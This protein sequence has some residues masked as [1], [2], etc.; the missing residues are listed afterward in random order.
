MTDE[1]GQARVHGQEAGEGVW[2]WLLRPVDMAS[3]AAF[4]I[5][6]GLMLCG[7]T[8]RF[9]ASGWLEPFFGEPTFFFKYWGFSWVRPLPLWGM[10]LL[11]G[12]L[13]VLAL[14]VALGFLYRLSMA[15]FT[16]GFA[17]AQLIDVTNYLNHYY[18]VVL[19]GGLMVLLPLHR[20]W[21]VDAWLRPRLRSTTAPAWVL[22]LLRLQVGLVYFHAGL[23]KF[24]SDWLL[25]AQPLNIWMSARTDTL[26]I[27][28]LLELPWVAYAMSWA[29]FLF[30]T[31]IVGF[32]LARRT[33]PFAYAVVLAFHFLTG[34]FFNIGLF[35]VIMVTSALVF[36]PPEWPRHLLR[37][38]LPVLPPAPVRPALSW[39]GKAGF[40]LLGA[41]C[42]FQAV[43][44]LRHFLYPGSVLWN[45][46]GMRWSW[47]VMLREKS[48]S[49]TYHVRSKATGREWQVTPSRYLTWRQAQEM[50]GQ[51]DLILQ[52]AHHVAREFE[53]QG[54]GP[55]EVRAEAWVSLNGR[56]PALLID[57]TVDLTQVEDGLL[58]AQWI[59]PEPA[60]PPPLLRAPRPRVA[61]HQP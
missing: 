51:P 31:T 57:R 38:P 18:L 36:F 44:P 14:C 10:Y 22:Y 39:A 42:L 43:F 34:T 35:P 8:L 16:L 53:Q 26:L 1:G 45:E 60:E 46:E 58:P 41:F 52:L 59:L 49:I 48:G 23:A 30:D 17:W 27:G 20:T 3:L 15:L 6:F 56:K 11:Y 32:L 7:G 2:E 40:A 28:P 21:S 61:N 55:V 13:A 25:H 12:A 19:L 29:G 54:H 33:R 4:R 37:R 24:G 50:S 47:K 5:L 9:I